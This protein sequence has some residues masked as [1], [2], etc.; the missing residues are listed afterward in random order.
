MRRTNSD[1]RIPLQPRTDNDT[2]LD[3][4]TI[5]AEIE[6]LTRYSST[7]NANKWEHT[8]QGLPESADT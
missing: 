5:D 6:S 2:A 1:V 7:I 3:G 4:I 8:I